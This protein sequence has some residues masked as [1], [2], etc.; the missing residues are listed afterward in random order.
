MVFTVNKGVIIKMNKKIS[1]LSGFMAFT[2]IIPSICSSSENRSAECTGLKEK[3]NYFSAAECYSKVSLKETFAMYMKA[4]ESKQ[5]TAEAA[6][7]IGDYYYYGFL[8]KDEAKAI[9]YYKKSAG[10][11]SGEAAR[12]LGKIYKYRAEVQ[13]KY[14]EKDEAI[15]YYKLA[16][17]LLPASER[18]EVCYNLGCL[19]DVAL[20][21]KKL[22]IKSYE[23]AYDYYLKAYNY[24]YYFAASALSRFY[25]FG[26]GVEKNKA[27][28]REWLEKGAE[29][30]NDLIIKYLVEDY[31]NGTL[32]KK[33]L[34]AAYVWMAVL[35]AKN[36]GD[37][38]YK[39][40]L[41]EL[42]KKFSS[43][44]LVTARDNAAEYVGKYVKNKK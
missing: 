2:L 5:H 39:S 15:K 33:D 13:K 7:K 6:Y 22:S 9:E 42:E 8:E 29:K 11:G 10:L 17:K 34:L 43:A 3:G 35:Q 32:G 36:P 30:G 14:E 40:S 20:V 4:F 38:G 26:T 44:E 16:E 37:D 18:G 1:V 19:Y 23:Q 28:A 27:K 24:G 12:T 21:D 41:K 31:A 25:E